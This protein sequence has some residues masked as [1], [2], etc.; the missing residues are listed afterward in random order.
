[1][2][3]ENN[4]AEIGKDLPDSKMEEPEVPINEMKEVEDDQSKVPKC[5]NNYKILVKRHPFEKILDDSLRICEDSMSKV[6]IFIF[7][8]QTDSEANL[9]KLLKIFEKEVMKKQEYF[10]LFQL[11]EKTKK[12]FLNFHFF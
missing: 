11:F 5:K 4:I 6:D 8:F 12:V 9:E 1:M 7:Y 3:I 10:L 2:N